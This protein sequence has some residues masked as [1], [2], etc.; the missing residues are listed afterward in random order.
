MTFSRNWGAGTAMAV[1]LLGATAAKAEPMA[2]EP[3]PPVA[4]WY[5]AIEFEAFADAYASVDWNF[6]KPHGG[7]RRVTRSFDRQDGFA[8]AWVGVDAS[9]EPDP[10]G[11]MLSLRF[12]PTAT[13]HAHGD[14]NIDLQYVGQ[15]FASWR[16]GGVDGPVR[17]DFGKFDTIYGAEVA[18]SQK[19]MNYTRGVLYQ[20]AQPVFHTGLRA[21][22]QLIPEMSLTALAVNGWNN[23][24]D[25]NTG[26][27]F[28]LQANVKPSD[29]LSASLG[30]LGGPEQD[31]SITTSCAAGT[32]YDP[33]AKGCA[34]APGAPASEEVVDRGGANKFE[35]WRHLVDL[36]VSAN[37]L[38]TV[39]VVVNADYGVEGVRSL[40]ADGETTTTTKKWYGAM[41]GARL[42]LDETYA[43]AARGEYYKA[44]DGYM[45]SLTVNEEPVTDLTLATATLTLEARPTENLILRLENRGD[46]VLD[47]SPNK[48]IFQ[49]AERDS[50]KNLLTTTLGVV[51]TTN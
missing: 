25:N 15:A 6:P 42:Q 45:P 33:A 32:E 43:I 7:E 47:A 10:V 26:K 2:P 23:S 44:P 11:G 37:P 40:G 49:K 24:Q 36:V 17:L 18:E 3:P 34:P 14:A 16:P 8:L 21:E 39:S 5:E 35:A 13:E 29:A 20:F 27:T 48:E 41:L 28:G 19:N 9:Y 4:P 46:F 50:A 12:G 51:V 30:W 31:D 22:A 38:E 1:T